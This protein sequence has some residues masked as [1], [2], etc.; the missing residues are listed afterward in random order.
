VESRA[1][2]AGHA[3][4]PMLIVFP[5]GLLA[6]AVVFDILYFAI[7]NTSL[8]TG[9]F[10]NISAG[11]ITG[12]LAAIFGCWDLLH[13]PDDTRAK[14]IGVW[15]GVGSVVVIALFAISGYLRSVAPQ[16]LPSLWPLSS[17]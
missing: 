1:K 9:A 5:L 4:H 13:I 12:L 8:A 10:L 16:H 15:H 11:I 14:V 2:L 17:C 6:V 7:G 3:I